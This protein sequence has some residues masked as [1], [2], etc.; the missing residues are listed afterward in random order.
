MKRVLLLFS[1]LLALLLAACAGQPAAEQPLQES[2]EP[3]VTVYRAP[4]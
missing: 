3:V 2:G 4:T 1:A